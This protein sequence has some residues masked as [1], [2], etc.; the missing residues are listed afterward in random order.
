[1]RVISRSSVVEES[2]IMS[3]PRNMGYMENVKPISNII[4][5]GEIMKVETRLGLGFAFIIILLLSVA[6]VGLSNIR[7]IQGDLDSL[8]NDKYPKTVWA[9]NIADNINIISRATLNE[10]DFERF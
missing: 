2:R 1:M 8:V 9:D 7:N 5:K 10:Q 3:A 6:A 4:H